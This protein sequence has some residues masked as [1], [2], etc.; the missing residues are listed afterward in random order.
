M[1][2]IKS[3]GFLEIVLCCRNHILLVN[4]KQCAQFDVRAET[5]LMEL[6]KVWH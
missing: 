6:K 3:K 4:R 5:T 2:P 1:I